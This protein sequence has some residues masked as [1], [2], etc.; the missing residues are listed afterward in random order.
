MTTPIL[1]G[2]ANARSALFASLLVGAATVVTNAFAGECPAGKMQANVR[3]PVNTPASGVTDTTLGSIDLGKEQVMLKDH[4]L[5]FRKLTIA[6]GGVVPWHSHADRP[7]I[8]FVAQG[9]IVEYASNCS[10]P[11]VHKAGDIRPET[12]G[13]SHWWKNLGDQIV[14]LYVGDVHHDKNDH[15]M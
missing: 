12:S 5:R 11:I 6:P 1:L 9:E 8:I 4:D 2:R 3:P 15:N 7:A 13:T 10:E 14:I